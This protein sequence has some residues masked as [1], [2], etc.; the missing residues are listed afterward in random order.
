MFSSIV[1]SV[2]ELLGGPGLYLLFL[3]HGQEIRVLLIRRPSQLHVR[4]EVRGQVGIG[5]GDGSKSGF[6][7]IEGV[8]NE[9]MGLLY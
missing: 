4:P 3:S 8:N 2:P 9:Y 1:F 7:C 6:S 5:V